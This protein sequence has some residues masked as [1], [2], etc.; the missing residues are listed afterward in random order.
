MQMIITLAQHK[1][2]VHFTR[3]LTLTAHVIIMYF[4][5]KMRNMS[6]QL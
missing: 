1:I 2:S 4:I 6:L 3:H 5:G